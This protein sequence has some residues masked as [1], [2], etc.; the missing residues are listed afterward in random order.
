MG[1]MVNHHIPLSAFAIVPPMVWRVWLLEQNSCGTQSP[2]AFGDLRSPSAFLTCT[3]SANQSDCGETQNH[4]IA[5][6]PEVDGEKPTKA[7][8]ADSKNS[9]WLHRQP[10]NPRL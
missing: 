1:L 5:L 7:N 8:Q 4:L 6:K 2:T 10:A 3:E 9:Y